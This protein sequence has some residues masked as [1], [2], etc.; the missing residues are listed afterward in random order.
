MAAQTRH[1]NPIRFYR[2][3]EAPNYS[4]FFPRFDNT[5]QRQQYRR[6][7]YPASW[8]KGFAE[9]K[10]ISF[11]MGILG[12]ITETIDV[13]KYEDGVASIVDTLSPIDIT[14]TGWVAEPQRKYD[15][16]PVETGVYY[17]DFVEGGLRSDEFVITDDLKFLTGFVQVEFENSRNDFGMIFDDNGTNVYRGLTYYT[18]TSI[19]AAPE[20]NRDVF[21]TDSLTNINLRVR[22]A[23]VEELILSDIHRDYIQ[24]INDVFSCDIL[25][26]NG[27]R[28]STPEGIEVDRKDTSDMYDVTINLVKY[29]EQYKY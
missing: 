19:M 1:M 8:Y 11:Q 2:P 4:G 29:S 6:G 3:A 22:N 15:F 16:L 23:M 5:T 18:G 20:S 7:E 10:T 14:P 28:F 25:H 17:F 27:V 9:N 21:T 26:V 13:Y 24:N 12:T